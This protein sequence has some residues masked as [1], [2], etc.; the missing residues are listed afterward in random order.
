MS[1]PAVSRAATCRRTWSRRAARRASARSSGSRRSAA[2]RPRVQPL[3]VAAGTCRAPAA[4]CRPRAHA[5]G[6]REQRRAHAPPPRAPMHEHLGEVGRGAAGSRAGPGR[7]APCRRWRPRR[8]RRRA[9]RARRAP[10]SAATPRQNASALA[11]D[12]GSMKL[13]EA[14]P[15]TQSISTSASAVDLASPSACSGESRMASGVMVISWRSGLGGDR[16]RRSARGLRVRLRN[17]VGAVELHGQAVVLRQA[18]VTLAERDLDAALQHPDLLVHARR[19]ARRSRR[20]RAR[21]PAARPRR[22]GSA[23]GSR[24]ARCCAGRSRTAGS[25]HGGGRRAARPGWRGARGV[26][27]ERGQRHAEAGGDLLQHHG[28]GA[29]LAALDQ[30]DH[31][32][33]DLALRGERIE[34]HP[35]RRRAARGRARRCGR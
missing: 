20:P 9:P 16:R 27:E 11:R 1:V 22:S 13:T 21:R 26:V 28:G 15:S 30:R 19:R 7:S 3:G 24:R 12:I 4:S 10:R 32:A 6:G 29:A 34:G 23:R 2:S 25:R 5:L 35:Q 14:P 17:A 31:R 18:M 8:P 33:A